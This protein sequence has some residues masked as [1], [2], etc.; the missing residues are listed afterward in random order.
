MPKTHEMTGTGV[1]SSWRCM[2]TRCLNKNGRWYYNYGGR[3]ITICA[4]WDSFEQF[5]RDMGDRP[6]GMS[7]ER[8]DNSLGYFSANCKW[9]TKREQAQNRRIPTVE[10]IEHKGVSLTRGE[11][12]VRVGIPY[13]TLK[14]RLQAG[15]PLEKVLVD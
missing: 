5:H 1:H 2:R 10:L 7:L 11:W 6:E 13:S 15:W 14:Y 9:A 3:G 8:I 4:E 12:A